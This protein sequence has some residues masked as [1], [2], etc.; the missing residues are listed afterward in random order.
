MYNAIEV[1][2]AVV[3]AIPSVDLSNN[4]VADLDL[5]VDVGKVAVLD[6][7]HLNPNVYAPFLNLV[8]ATILYT[9]LLLVLVR[10]FLKLTN[11]LHKN[12]TL[13]HSALSI[14]SLASSIN[15]KNV[16]DEYY[17]ATLFLT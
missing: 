1:L 11:T 16:Y 7:T 5:F 12:Y 6:S 15:R 10:I 9:G 3:L 8:V 13:V 2:Q 4:T 17:T 14:L